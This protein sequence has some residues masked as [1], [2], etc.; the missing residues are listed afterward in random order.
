MNKYNQFSYYFETQES[1]AF[2]EALTTRQSKIEQDQ[3]DKITLSE[4]LRLLIKEMK[5]SKS[6]VIEACLHLDD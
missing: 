3:E 4:T 6:E 1:K 2:V 5:I